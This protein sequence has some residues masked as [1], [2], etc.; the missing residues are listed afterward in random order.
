MDGSASGAAMDRRLAPVG[1]HHRRP[2]CWKRVLTP[3]Q[4]TTKLHTQLVSGSIAVPSRVVFR[5]PIRSR[6]RSTGPSDEQINFIRCELE[7]ARLEVG[8]GLDGFDGKSNPEGFVGEQSVHDDP[9]HLLRHG[10]L[11][12]RGLAAGGDP[13][14]AIS[15]ATVSG[16]AHGVWSTHH[17]PNG[18]MSASGLHRIARDRAQAMSARDHG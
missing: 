11:S 6:T 15:A 12:L 2:S 10:C 16:V 7:A 18:N 5:L 17:R 13:F 9:D 14:N 1:P 4:A 8:Q 3:D